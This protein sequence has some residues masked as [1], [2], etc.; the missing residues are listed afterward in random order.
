MVISS[1]LTNRFKKK[2]STAEQKRLLK[3]KTP[4]LIEGFSLEA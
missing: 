4:E 2:W 1:I 3:Q